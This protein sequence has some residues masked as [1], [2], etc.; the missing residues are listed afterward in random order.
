ME[1]AKGFIYALCLLLM[2]WRLY[3]NIEFQISVAV[4]KNPTDRV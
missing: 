3:G 4:T 1:V 2:K